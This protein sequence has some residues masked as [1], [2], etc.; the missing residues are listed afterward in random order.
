MHD[1]TPP[2]V[3]HDQEA[4]PRPAA[5]PHPRNWTEVIDLWPIISQ[6]RDS[7]AFE[8]DPPPQIR[9]GQRLIL[10][11]GSKRLGPPDAASEAV[12]GAI[13]DFD[14]LV[15]IA[16]ATSTAQSWPDLVAVP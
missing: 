9:M 13:H 12:L 3:P 16:G 5:V 2:T 6:M 10:L 11:R 14:R 15:R 1:S 4:N 7:S 8:L